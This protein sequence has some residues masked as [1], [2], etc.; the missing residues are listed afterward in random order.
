MIF[1][2]FSRFA[3]RRFARG[4]SLASEAGTGFAS[5]DRAA[6]ALPFAVDRRVSV[7]SEANAAGSLPLF[8]FGG[9]Q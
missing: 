5:A 8:R 3:S 2:H 6:F 7:R 1:L 9:G 4:F